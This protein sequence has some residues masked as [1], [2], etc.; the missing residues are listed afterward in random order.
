MVNSKPIY[1]ITDNEEFQAIIWETELGRIITCE[2]K[3]DIKNNMSVRK[4]ETGEE[5]VDIDLRNV[6][7]SI[8]P[9]K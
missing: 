3:L 2:G 4:V 8:L 5:V 9:S 6:L 1:C 7:M